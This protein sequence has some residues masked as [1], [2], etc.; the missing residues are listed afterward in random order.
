MGSCAVFPTL[1]YSSDVTSHSP[2]GR[3]VPWGKPWVLDGTSPEPC[4]SFLGCHPTEPPE[5]GKGTPQPASQ[6]DSHPTPVWPWSGGV[7]ASAWFNAVALSIKRI[8]LCTAFTCPVLPSPAS[9]REHGRAHGGRYSSASAPLTAP[10]SPKVQSSSW[11][12]EKSEASS[13]E[14]KCGHLSVSE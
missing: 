14:R 13:M 12:G 9:P 8:C 2:G 1:R 11:K 4:L 5:P 7:S 6:C 10:C 3:P